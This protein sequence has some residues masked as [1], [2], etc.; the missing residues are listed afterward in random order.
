MGFSRQEYWSGVPLPSLMF[1]HRCSQFYFFIP[2][3]R[4]PHPKKYDVPTKNLLLFSHSAV[5]DSETH[6][7]QHARLPCPSPQVCSLSWWCH[8]TISSSVTPSSSC[9]LSFPTSGSFP[10]SWLFGS[11]GQ[12]IGA[13]ASAS[14]LPMNIQGW[15]PLRLTGLI[16]LQSKGLSRVFSSTRVQKH[17]YFAFSILYG[18]THICTWLLEIW[19][20]VSSNGVIPLVFWCSAGPVLFPEEVSFY[21]IFRSNTGSSLCSDH[22]IYFIH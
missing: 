22:S 13:S 17:Q 16:S 19:K 11:G 12:S 2:L 4:P 15:V 1:Y 18:S 6:G 10:V 8:Q 5:S 20:N 21:D 7:L 3:Q 14:V 9:L